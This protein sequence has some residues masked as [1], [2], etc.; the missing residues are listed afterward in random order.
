MA[1]RKE[2]AICC[3]ERSNDM[4]DGL[5]VEYKKKTNSSHRP[6][7]SMMSIRTSSKVYTK[8]PRLTAHNRNVDTKKMVETESKRTENV[9]RDEES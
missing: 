4:M 3:W 7:D 5:K 1:A 2:K 9:I 6:R 8:D